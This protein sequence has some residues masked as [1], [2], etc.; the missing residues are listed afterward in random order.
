MKTIQLAALAALSSAAFGCAGIDPST[1]NETPTEAAKTEVK[2]KPDADWSC[3]GRKTLPP[4]P[5]ARTGGQT[6]DGV[7]VYV[8][9]AVTRQGMPGLTVEACAL[10]DEYCVAPLGSAKTDEQGNAI[11]AVPGGID[12]FEGYFQVQGGGALVNLEFTSVLK[13]VVQEYEGIAYTASTLELT[14]EE[15]GVT[16]DPR[17]AFVQIEA[18]DCAGLPAAGVV[19]L[20]AEEDFHTRMAYSAGGI[21]APYPGADSTDRTGLG[22]AFDVPAGRLSV[23]A[24]LASTGES[25]GRALAFTRRGGVSVIEVTPFQ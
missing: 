14:A 2:S 8:P 7:V 19:F 3:L 6:A 15:A 1:R 23:T 22:F 20:V 21:G 5:P 9:E 13:P 11:V 4:S 25:I 18:L 17:R 24:S 10:Q 16:N 12:A